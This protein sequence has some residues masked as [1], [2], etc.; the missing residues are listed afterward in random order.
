MSRKTKFTRERTEI[1]LGLIREGYSIT[2]ACRSVGIGRS[3]YYKWLDEYPD[4]NKAVC[5]DTDLQ[6]RYAY[7]MVRRRKKRGY[8]RRLNRPAKDY[9]SP[10]NLPFTMPNVDSGKS[11]DEIYEEWL[12]TE[13][14]KNA[15]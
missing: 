6:W 7:D 1:I 12:R 3:T 14:V 9:Q 15:Y 4:L 11:V 8:N 2:D 13:S 5:E 10:N